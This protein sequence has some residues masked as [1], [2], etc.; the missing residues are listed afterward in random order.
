LEINRIYLDH[1]YFTDIITFDY[2]KG[3][4][5][6]GDIHISVERVIENAR[7][8]A[9]SFKEELHRV[10]VHGILHLIGFNDATDEEKM[11]MRQ[12]EN[13]CLSLLSE[14]I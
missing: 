12:Q 13:Y 9:L 6:S 1:D 10:M 11:V 5:I 2:G 4:I 3:N 14:I 7:V 8:M